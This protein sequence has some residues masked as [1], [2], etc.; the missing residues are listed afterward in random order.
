[1]WSLLL[2]PPILSQEEDT[3]SS[4]TGALVLGKEE[5]CVHSP[6]LMEGREEEAEVS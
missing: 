6:W 2:F 5:T 3:S 1:M 4:C